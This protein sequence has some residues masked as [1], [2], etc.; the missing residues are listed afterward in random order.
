MG[1]ATQGT[2]DLVVARDGGGVTGGQA[3]AET[4]GF[5]SPLGTYLMLQ[6]LGLAAALFFL[7]LRY[8]PGK[9]R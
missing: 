2:L 1:S 6:F 5:F 8:A 3:L 7:A 4:G 9:R